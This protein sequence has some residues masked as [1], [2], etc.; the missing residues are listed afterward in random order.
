MLDDDGDLKIDE[1]GEP[2]VGDVTAQNQRILIE[3][4]KGD[5][6]LY[7]LIGVGAEDFIDNENYND[8]LREIRLQFKKDGLKINLLEA[9]NNEIKIDAYYP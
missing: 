9:I 5:L 8:L 1:N 7:P 2:V 3:T 6:K 4:N